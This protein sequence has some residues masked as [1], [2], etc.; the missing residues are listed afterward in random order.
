[1]L[2]KKIFNLKTCV[3]NAISFALDNIL[4]IEMQYREKDY[5]LRSYYR[6]HVFFEPILSQFTLMERGKHDV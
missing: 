5:L 2:D 6:N 1:M 3:A 4:K